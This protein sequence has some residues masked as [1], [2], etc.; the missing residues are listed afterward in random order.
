[1]YLTTFKKFLKYYGRGKK[2]KL[3][4]FF[5]LATIAGM[6]EFVG[7]SL[8]YPFVMAIINPNEI[9][10][11]IVFL[12]QYFQTLSPFAIAILIGIGAMMIF[13]FKNLYMVMFINIQSKFLQNWAKSISE[14]FMNYFLYAPYKNVQK[15]PNTEKLYVLSFLSVQTTNGYIMRLMTLITNVIIVFFVVGFILYKFFVAGIISFCFVIGSIIIQNKLFKSKISVVNDKIAGTTK[16][17]GKISYS[18]VNCIKDIKIEGTENFF[19]QKYQILLKE[20]TDENAA[21]VFF[22]GIS[23]YIVETLIVLSLVLLAIIIIFESHGEGYKTV[24]SFAMIIA[25]IFRIAP[26][27]N[28][29]QSSIINLPSTKN[30]TKDLVEFYE[31]YEFKPLSKNIKINTEK[32]EFRDKIELRNVNFSYIDGCPVLKNINLEINKGDFVGI[33]GLSGAGKSTLADVLTGLLPIDSG[34][35]KLDGIIL[36]EEKIYGYRKNIGYVQQE[37]TVLESSFRENIAWGIAEEEIDNSRVEKIIE[38]VQ[39]KSLVDK[40]PNGIYSVPFVDENGLSRGQKQRL[41]IARALYR[42]PE[43][44]I[45]DEATSALDVKTEHEITEMLQEL[46]KHKTIIAIAHRLSTLKA[47]NKIVFM[48]EGQIKDVG[49]FEYLKANYPEFEE[50]IR[51]S[52]LE[53]KEE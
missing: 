44:L 7:I 39:L 5:I 19:K 9:S 50:M 33:I 38:E 52:S 45:F 43:I 10:K 13:V 32:I 18:N 53:L 24:A 25:A 47:C 35:I 20:L 21:L 3:F 36:N 49:S 51:L 29:I 12:P 37:L 48:T 41:A 15:I 23:P 42:E 28:R 17:I 11:F 34:E 16:Q 40:Y 6:L 30:F 1:M 22:S 8:I 31:K 27:L 46:K 26:A 4:L 14:Y 2:L